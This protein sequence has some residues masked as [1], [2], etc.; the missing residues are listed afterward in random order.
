MFGKSSSPMQA[1]MGMVLTFLGIVLWATLFDTILAQFDTLMGYSHLSSFTLLQTMYQIGPVIL[2]LGVLGLLGWGY[3][4]SYMNSN[5][6]GSGVN[7]LMWVVFGALQIPAFSG[8]ILDRHRLAVHHSPGL[9]HREL[10]RVADSGPNLRGNHLSFR[11]FRRGLEY[12]NR[13]S[14]PEKEKISRSYQWHRHPGLVLPGRLIGLVEGPPSSLQTVS[15]T[16]GLSYKI[17]EIT[18]GKYGT[19]R[20]LNEN[21]GRMV[22]VD[23]PRHT[24][25]DGENGVIHYDAL[26]NTV[27][28]AWQHQGLYPQRQTFQDER[29]GAESGNAQRCYWLGG[30]CKP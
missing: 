11:Y 6:Q 25:A 28:L 5:K 15:N 24:F 16:R 26:N 27:V 13:Y 20:T 17:E 4:N 23:A 19:T 2:F 8:A 1:F 12:L 3:Y 22:S 29:R 21:T 14:Q 18:M 30:R 9:Q 7:M 10:H